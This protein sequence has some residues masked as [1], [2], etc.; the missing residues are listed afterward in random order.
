ML[1]SVAALIAFSALALCGHDASTCIGLDPTDTQYIPIITAA[2]FTMLWQTLCSDE[3]GWFVADA[4]AA[5]GKLSKSPDN[6]V[7]LEIKSPQESSPVEPKQ[8]DSSSNWMVFYATFPKYHCT[9]FNS[10]QVMMLA[11]QT[12]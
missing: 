4:Q 3:P 5:G 9:M 2:V 12:E 1:H 8:K 7:E 6:S 11:E 10:I